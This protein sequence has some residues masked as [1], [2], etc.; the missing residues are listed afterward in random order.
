MSNDPSDWKLRGKYF[1]LVFES[2]ES[3]VSLIQVSR[4]IGQG[5]KLPNAS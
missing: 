3:L 4:Q 1:F 2:I 5:T